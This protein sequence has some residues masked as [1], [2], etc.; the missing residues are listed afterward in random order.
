MKITR[1]YKV[2]LDLNNKQKTACLKHAGCARFAF[3][4]GLARKKQ[5]FQLGQKIP[6]AVDLH[7][8]L[9]ALKATDYPWMYECSKCA[10]QEAL[11]DLDV[12]YKNAFRRL[13]EKKA[14]KKSV[15]VG[16]P[17]FKS[18]NKGIGGF[19]LTG[20]IHIHKKTIQLPRLG[21]LR[22]KE[23]N[24]LPVGAKV[25]QATVTERAGR[26]Y[27]SVQL[28]S[29]IGE[30]PA[31]QDAPIGIDVGIKALATCS[32]GTSYPNPKALRTRLKQLRRA[33]RRVSSKKKGSKNRAK[34]RKK[35]AR[36]HAKIANLR[37]DTLQKTTTAMVT[38]ATSNGSRASCMVI[39]DLHIAG[40]LK[41]RRLSRAIA[42]VGLS[43]FRR[44]LTYKLEAAGIPLKVVSRWYPSSKTC[45]A[46]GWIDEDQ[47][48]SD[49]TFVC[50]HCGLVLDRDANAA[51]T[52]AQAAYE[53]FGLPPVRRECTAVEIVSDLGNKATVAEAATEHG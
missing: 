46:C 8:E 20:S 44:Q 23:Q 15:K 38:K 43:E 5:A 10:P 7:K 33:S 12:A 51:R 41:N 4:W 50:E 24:Y 18:R 30:I 53:L 29:E 22:L 40:M 1:G 14:G 11:R 31:G 13:K 16:W 27:V 45:S 19:R 35:L 3:N 21:K 26:W 49:R 17:R 52:L 47:T 34:A 25:A 48:L 9:N 42:D 32:D 28:E 2:E 39:E 37:K 6:T 36:V